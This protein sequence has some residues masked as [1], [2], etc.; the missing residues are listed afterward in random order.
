MNALTACKRIL[1][2]WTR[3]LENTVLFF[4]L[5][6]WT[7]KCYQLDILCFKEKRRLQCKVA[8]NQAQMLT[9]QLSYRTE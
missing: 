8:E 9:N 6:K 4:L 3:I 1:E 5:R 2:I 7:T